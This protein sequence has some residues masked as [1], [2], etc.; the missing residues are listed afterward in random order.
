MEDAARDA[1][2]A[3]RV[4]EEVRAQELGRLRDVVCRLLRAQQACGA[5]ECKL[6]IALALDR[7]ITPTGC[8]HP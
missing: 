4:A 8:I 1:S 2:S 6:V 7:L 3:Y 5:L